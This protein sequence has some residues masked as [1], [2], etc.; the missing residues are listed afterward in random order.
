MLQFLIKGGPIM[1]PLL[2]C[3]ILALAIIIEKFVSLRIIEF[4]SD[5]FMKRAL[6]IL[7]SDEERKIDKVLALCEMTSS[8]PARILRAGIEKKEVGSAEVKEAVGDAGSMEVPHLGR[9]LM[10]LGTIVTISP[11]LGLLGTVRGMIRA[12]NEIAVAGVG[13]PGALAGGISEALYTT[14]FGLGI[15][16]PA[17][18]FYNYFTHRTDRLVQKLESFSSEFLE[19]LT[20]R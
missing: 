5:K 19:L 4:K 3:S 1:I 14:A 18:V 16:I 6:G 11:L 10:V 13:D 20:R 8:P 9:F 15:A 17:L 7:N 12:F 2:F